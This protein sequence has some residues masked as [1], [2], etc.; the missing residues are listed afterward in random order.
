M[1]IEY[2]AVT[3]QHLDDG[4]PPAS[5]VHEWR[6]RHTDD[7]KITDAPGDLVRLRNRTI[8]M[9]PTTATQCGIKQVLVWPHYAL[10]HAR[11]AAC[12]QQKH[13]IVGSLIKITCS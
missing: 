5:A 4:I 11:S 9:K 12:I 3:T 10:R 7:G 6:K 1:G 8:W 13:V 2:H